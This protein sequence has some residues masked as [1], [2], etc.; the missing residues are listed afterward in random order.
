MGE[1]HVGESMYCQLTVSSQAALNTEPIVLSRMELN[2]S[3]APRR[4]QVDHNGPQDENKKIQPIDVQE[5]LETNNAA[6]KMLAG[7]ASLVFRPQTIQVFEFALPLRESDLFGATGARLELGGQKRKLGYVFNQPDDLLTNTWWLESGSGFIAKGLGR[8][9]PHMINV[10]AKPPKVQI[11][12]EDLKEGYFTGEKIVLNVQIANEEAQAVHG[13]VKISRQEN[14][15]SELRLA[16]ENAEGAAIEDTSLPAV[17]A[18]CSVEK[19]APS[20]SQTLRLSLI[21]PPHPSESTLSIQITYYLEDDPSTPLSKTLTLL[22]PFVNPFE[23]KYDLKPRVD[24]VAWPSFFT[25][26]ETISMSDS[27]PN[28]HANGILQ[29]W[30]LA[31]RIVSCATNE[32]LIAEEACLAVKKMTGNAICNTT[33][34]ISTNALPLTI[35]PNITRSIPFVFTTQKLSLEDRRPSALDLSLTVKWRRS[36]SSSSNKSTAE[37][38]STTLAIPQFTLPAAEPRVLCSSRAA[39]DDDVGISQLR[40]SYM[41]ENPTMH[42]LTFTLTMSASDSFAFSGPKF[43]TV[44]LTPM[45]RVTVEYN[46]YVYAATDKEREDEKHKARADDKKGAE[47][48]QEKVKGRWIS[49]TLKVVDAYFQKTLK[50]L[51]AGE[52][53]RSDGKGGVEVWVAED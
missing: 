23:A 16:W 7:T 48:E 47:L 3:G 38:A 36:S 30:S 12:L 42:F 49:P 50:V 44:S 14:D 27:Q 34:A 53:V 31:T 32:T 26:P 1:G 17:S 22:L 5:T 29:R 28:H 37:F 21:A 8:D 39:I 52:G 4:L 11:R 6:A 13:T 18:A 33:N 2:F 10:L 35:E 19:L 25:L 41:L 15:S 51:D 43:K 24:H 9:R 45:S 20:T 40:L 46:L